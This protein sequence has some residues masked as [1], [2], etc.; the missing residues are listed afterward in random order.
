MQGIFLMKGLILLPLQQNA[1]QDS[2]QQAN[3][4]KQ[5][6]SGHP[7]LYSNQLC[8]QQYGMG[9]LTCLGIVASELALFSSP[10]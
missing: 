3:D 6:A 1:K 8:E 4:G 5:H 10:F 9:Y 2:F 7:C